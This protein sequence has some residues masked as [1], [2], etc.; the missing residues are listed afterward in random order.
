MDFSY[1]KNSYRLRKQKAL[2]DDSRAI[3]QIIFTD[4]IKAELENKE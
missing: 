4:K 3:Q 1:F 2:D